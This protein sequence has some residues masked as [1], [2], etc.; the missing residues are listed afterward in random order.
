MIMRFYNKFYDLII[1]KFYD[2]VL[3][4]ISNIFLQII[5]FQK[6]KK[7]HSKN[8]KNQRFVKYIKQYL[9]NIYDDFYFRR[10]FFNQNIE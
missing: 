4:M 5:I 1:M 2:N 6:L 10:E 3:I 8:I 9:I 7:L